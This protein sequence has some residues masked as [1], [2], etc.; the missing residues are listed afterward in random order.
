MLSP[1]PVSMESILL[2]MASRPSLES[3]TP[4]RTSFATCF[5]A[6]VIFPTGRLLAVYAELI[7]SLSSLTSPVNF[8]SSLRNSR[9][10]VLLFALLCRASA[11]DCLLALASKLVLTKL[12]SHLKD[13]SFRI[14]FRSIMTTL[15]SG[16]WFWMPPEFLLGK[17]IL[18]TSPATP[19]SLSLSAITVLSTPTIF[20]TTL[21]CKSFPLWRSLPISDSSSARSL[22]R[23]EA[24]ARR[25]DSRSF[26]SLTTS[27]FREVTSSF[28][29]ASDASKA[30]L[31]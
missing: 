7:F 18:S 25:S 12:P 1:M 27:S 4:S 10:T 9:V 31:T 29:L 6:S 21:P 3:R 13:R 24:R 17:L 2:V 14:L 8:S 20:L 22:C 16:L 26:V 30:C 15:T 5:N 11:T 23:S 28:H 19:S